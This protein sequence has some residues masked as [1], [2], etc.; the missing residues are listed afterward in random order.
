MEDYGIGLIALS[1]RVFQHEIQSVLGL[2]YIGSWE[3]VE[4]MKFV[5]EHFLT[6]E[7]NSTFLAD[8]GVS[9]NMQRQQVETLKGTNIIIKQGDFPQSTCKVLE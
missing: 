5:R 1:N 9:G 6:K 3:S 8:E 7:L 4:T 2:K